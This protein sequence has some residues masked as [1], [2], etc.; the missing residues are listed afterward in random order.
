MPPNI[1]IN[2]ALTSLYEII[3]FKAP[4]TFSFEAPPPTSRK[5]AG[6]DP[7]SLIISIVAIAKPAP[8]T[9]QP[10]LPSSFT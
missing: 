9:I 6:E 7:Y 3:I 2:I 4:D 5:F 10:N 1:L 8:F